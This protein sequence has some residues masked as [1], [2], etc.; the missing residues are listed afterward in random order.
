MKSQV[1]KLHDQNV[2]ASSSREAEPLGE[3]VDRDLLKGF[4]LMQCGSWLSSFL[5]YSFQVLDHPNH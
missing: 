1:F 3:D 4:D 5:T 2:N